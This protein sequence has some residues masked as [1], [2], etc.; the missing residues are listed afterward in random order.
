MEMG[1]DLS[2]VKGTGPD[3]AIT[4]GDVER[5]AVTKAVPEVVPVVTPPPP[6]TAPSVE[7]PKASASR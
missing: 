4:K 3:G 6:P 5:A 1:V 7:A 2:T